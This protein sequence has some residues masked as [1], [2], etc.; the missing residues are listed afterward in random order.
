MTGIMDRRTI[1]TPSYYNRLLTR[2]ALI[3]ILLAGFGL[4]AYYMRTV[5]PFE[6]EF[7]SMLASQA[8]QHSLLPI[9]PSGLFYVQGL[10]YSIVNALLIGLLQSAG[11][12][13]LP[14]AL[15]V[16]YRLPSVFINMLTIA[17][18]YRAGREWFSPLMAR[19]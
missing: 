17:L 12:G 5:H 16:P 1:I 10:P 7:I 18:T 6:D 19:G 3:G 4:C 9:L 13:S 15:Q 11:N 8:V 14:E 2:F